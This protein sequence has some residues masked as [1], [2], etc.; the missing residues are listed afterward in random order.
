ML[1]IFCKIET[2]LLQFN[3][4]TMWLEQTLTDIKK[5]KKKTKQTSMPVTYITS[6]G[7]K[8]RIRAIGMRH[9][10]MAVTYQQRIE[11]SRIR[12][13]NKMCNH[14]LISNSSDMCKNVSVA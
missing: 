1:I 8:F 4:A 11:K 14:N 9:T 6:H 7:C 5:T 3:S 10:L 2:G 12:I 13:S